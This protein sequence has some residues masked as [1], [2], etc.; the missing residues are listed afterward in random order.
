MCMVDYSDSCGMWL[1]SPH[2]V[3]AR[4]AHR[5][6]NCGK[7]IE[8]GETYWSGTWVED[9]EGIMPVVHCSFCLIA[10][11]WLNKVCSGH[12]WGGSAI[13]EDLAEHWDEEWQFRCRSFALLLA[14]MRKGWEGKTM[15]NVE[16][17]TKYAT[18]HALRVLEKVPA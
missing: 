14:G 11:G 3:K 15:K 1:T 17:L 2:E 7:R 18:A 9:G 12:L 10:A 5:C 16:S 4:K 13:Y 8:K 6:E